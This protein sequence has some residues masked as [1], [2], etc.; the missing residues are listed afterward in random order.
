MPLMILIF[1]KDQN[2]HNRRLQAVLKK[3]QESGITLNKDKCEFS[4]NR[5]LFLGH[6]IDSN[7]ISADPSNVSHHANET[8]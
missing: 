2:E 7:G 5:L 1:G 8:T 6:I 4:K 3:I